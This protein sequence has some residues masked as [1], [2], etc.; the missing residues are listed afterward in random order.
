VGLHRRGRRPGWGLDVVN[1]KAF[2]VDALSSALDLGVATPD[3][4]LRHVTPDLLAIHLPRP[5]WARL[6]TACIGAPRVD[7]RIVVETVGVPN[8]CEHIPPTVI[9]ACLAEI[10]GRVLGAQLSRIPP[11][12][13]VTTPTP[14]TTSTPR[15]TPLAITS[16]PP[17]EVKP[18]APPAPAAVLGTSIPTPSKDSPSGGVSAEADAGERPPPSRTRMP[19]SQRFRQTNT[20]IGRLAAT[21]ARRPQAQAVAPT[22]ANDAGATA[23]RRPRRVETEVEVESETEVGS[24]SREDWR[25]TLA[26]EDDQ[27]VEWAGAE[28]TLTSD[29]DGH[30]RKR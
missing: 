5:L 19:T 7:A 15:S 18:E 4:V 26:V 16:P 24:A 2:F 23:T 8:L 30:G 10:G 28:E 20:N 14:V 17:P 22:P 12:P 11:P 9:W 21:N 1:L 29:I 3:D 27:L 25:S 6:L 13:P